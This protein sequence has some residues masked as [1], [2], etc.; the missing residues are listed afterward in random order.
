MNVFVF[1]EPHSLMQAE[2]SP[3]VISSEWICSSSRRAPRFLKSEVLDPEV[4]GVVTLP[5][6][7][8][9]SNS[10][11]QVQEPI[12]SRPAAPATK[13]ADKT[14]A[15][16]MDQVQECSLPQHSSSSFLPT[17]SSCLAPVQPL[18]FKSFAMSTRPKSSVAQVRPS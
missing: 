8:L 4:A 18:A 7:P 6:G 13:E 5:A 9:E 16:L 3:Q 2:K 1:K 14:F 11:F 15:P 10:S 12:P 17:S